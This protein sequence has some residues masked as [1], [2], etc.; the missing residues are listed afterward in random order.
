MDA[1]QFAQ[2]YGAIT[3]REANE[4]AD[5]AAERQERTT[6]RARAE[7][8]RRLTTQTKA[9]KACDGSST[10]LVREW[11]MNMEIARTKLVG[12]QLEDLTLRLIS[13]TLQGPMWR[14]YEKWV[15]A[16]ATRPGPLAPL[17]WDTVKT[18]L[19]SAYLTLDESE[20]LKSEVE[21]I[22]QS[23]YESTG[24]F[25]RRFTEATD[26]AYPVDTRNDT[27]MGQLLEK[28]LKGLKSDVL[29]S[30]V[31]QEGRPT[32]LAEAT[33]SVEMF[34]AEIEKIRRLRSG[35]AP[36]PSRERQTRQEEPMEVNLV[37]RTTGATRY[38]ED[39]ADLSDYCPDRLNQHL[40]DIAA[41]AGGPGA[42]AG[43]SS[44]PQATQATQDKLDIL[45]NAMGNLTAQMGGLNNQLGGLSKEV[46]KLKNQTLY[47]SHSTGK[48]P[49]GGADAPAAMTTGYRH[50]F[51]GNDAPAAMT[52]GYRNN[53]PGKAALEWH[54]DGRPIC[55]E[56]KEAG[57][58]GKGCPRRIERLART[59]G[60]GNASQ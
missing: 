37:A 53:F 15:I 14:F 27:V 17:V 45:M 46:T 49:P 31:I 34:T 20:Y 29:V 48:T 33:A 57:H 12:P 19:R 54:A 43:T 44:R 4:H 1:N 52:T 28:Y 51:P 50:N 6:E 3:T 23:N 21:S 55:Y 35:H 22:R 11:F 16:Y 5:R 60:N 47:V 56:C 32:T 7:R 58:R 10:V 30:R 8:Q 36:A 9:V 39:E 26:L 59:S 42:A 18:A 41:V 24:A 13:E 40:D 25:S 38:S 2:F